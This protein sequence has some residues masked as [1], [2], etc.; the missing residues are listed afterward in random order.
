[1]LDQVESSNN[2][3]IARIQ[4][5][6]VAP[7]T[8][9]LQLQNF[10]G[11]KQVITNHMHGPQLQSSELVY[12]RK[13]IPRWVGRSTWH[14]S[15]Y[16]GLASLGCHQVLNLHIIVPKTCNFIFYSFLISAYCVTNMHMW[17]LDT[18]GIIEE[19]VENLKLQTLIKQVAVWRAWCILS[20][21]CTC[22]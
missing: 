3:L 21:E 4:S 22:I 15:I 11:Q 10:L 2:S 14:H 8:T 5:T 6:S 9:Y 12:L 18:L 1:M 20:E 17:C 16:P 19:P 13:K 7:L